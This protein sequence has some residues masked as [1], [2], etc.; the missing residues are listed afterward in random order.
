MDGIKTDAG[1]LEEEAQ[2]VDQMIEVIGEVTLEK[3]AEIQAAREAY[4]GLA[5]G[6]KAKVTKLAVLEAAEAKLAQLEAAV[7]QEE[8]DKAAAKAVEDKI[9]AIGMV[10]L[11]KE[12]IIA[13]A[14]AAF[15]GLTPAQRTFV[16]NE[17]VLEA[18]EAKLVQLLGEP[19]IQIDYENSSQTN[20]SHAFLWVKGESEKIKVRVLADFDTFLEK[21]VVDGSILDP[22]SYTV[23]D[24]SILIQFDKGYL[25]GLTNGEH[26]FQVYTKNGFAAGTILVSAKEQP[27]VDPDDPGN[28]VDPEK[29]VV[30]PGKPDDT[31][32][33]GTLKDGKASGIKPAKTGDSASTG[34]I[35]IAAFLALVL[36]TA[37]VHSIKKNQ[38]INR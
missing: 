24:G 8:L 19:L 3:K 12:E 1:L 37:G 7:A 26:K 18:A 15:D 16:P 17:A 30:D 21:I 6:A 38:K 13:K 32:K 27:P 10:D 25:N 36:C 33:S 11:S 22:N 4:D 5:D 14:R 9:A 20:D 2:G 31:G 29:P 34:I 28:P 23:S 35:W